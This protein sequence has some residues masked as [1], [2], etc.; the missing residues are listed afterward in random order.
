MLSVTAFV[1]RPLKQIASVAW[2]P[3]W[4]TMHGATATIIGD[5]LNL[6]T[7]YSFGEWI[8]QRRTHLRFTQRAIAE[9]VFC[10]TA[11]IKK[12]EADERQPSPELAELLAQALQVP[13]AFRPVFLACARGERAVDTLPPGFAAETMAVEP[14]GQTAHTLPFA[15]TPFVGRTAELPEVAALLANPACR[16]LTLLGPGGIGKTRLAIEAARAAQES[17]IN[18]VAFVPLAAV[19]GAAQLPDAIAHTLE[20]PLTGPAAPQV[21][22]VLQR[23]TVLLVLDNCEQLAGDLAWL[24][25]LLAKASGV[26][27]LATARGRLQ[28]AEEWIYPVPGLSE[29]AELFAQAARRVKPSFDP[30][31]AAPSIARIC[32]LVEGLPLA[33][34]LAAGWTPYM[35]CPAIAD[36]IRRDIDILATDVRNVPERHRSMRA[37]FDH[38]W[39]LLSPAEQDALMRL[40][41]FRGGWLVDEAKT[42]AGADLR[43]LRA[44]AEKSLV[45]VSEHGRFD[46]HELVRQYAGARLQAAG[47]ETDTRQR[48]AE[49]YRSLGEQM[50]AVFMN[51][52]DAVFWRLDQEQDNCRA[53]LQWWL[54][55]RQA[56]AAL[57]MVEALGQY[58]FWRGYREEGVRWISTVLAQVSQEDS[59]LLGR[60]LFHLSTLLGRLGRTEEAIASFQRG[61]GMAHRLEAPE[62]LIPML[63]VGSQLMPDRRQAQAALDQVFAIHESLDKTQQ[64]PFIAAAYALYGDLMRESGRYAEARLY[65]EK[66]LAIQRRSGATPFFTA[67]QT[68]NLGRLALQ[69]GQMDEAYGL[70]DEAVALVRAHRNYK[71]LADWLVRL[72]EVES[73]MGK[74][75][76]AAAHLRE[77]LQLFVDMSEPRGQADVRAGLAYLALQTEDTPGAVR[78]IRQSLGLYRSLYEKAD[79]SRLDGRFVGPE[80]VDAL[81]RAGLVALAAA[82]PMVAATCFGAVTQLSA[83]INHTPVPPLQE[84]LE[85]SLA[86][87]RQQLGVSFQTPWDAGQALPIEEVLSMSI[88]FPNG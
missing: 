34:E 45:R 79:R 72:G 25:E 57:P 50:T 9:Q 20:I 41:V 32:R 1:V 8:K 84:A 27:V 60:V 67:L 69:A 23:R 78:H 13:P 74:Y 33:V 2:S 17:F 38:S 40:S 37:V 66:S 42:V 51:L 52:S 36:H 11:M 10:S 14:G 71:G 39:E 30:T 76:T 86:K 49:A 83:R 46:M 88:H 58:W 80:F 26:K 68:G 29:A 24:S 48:H 4:D 54:D 28:L 15:A 77:C 55:S 12:I 63:S 87:I 59:V 44:L 61:L 3:F 5:D 6:T 7:T 16:L 19:T 35:T 53:A 22:R 75:D 70:M 43:L 85:T 65:Y 56:A 64:V 21:L 73:Y 62:L 31:T 18:G 47:L 82:Q 81:L